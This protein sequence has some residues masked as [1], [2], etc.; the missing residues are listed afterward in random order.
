[1]EKIH[2][3]FAFPC[4]LVERAWNVTKENRWNL[5]WLVK[6]PSDFIRIGYG[7]RKRGDGKCESK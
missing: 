7:Q 6:A 5:L 4:R 3:L 2:R 1:M